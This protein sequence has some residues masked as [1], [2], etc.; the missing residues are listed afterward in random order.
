MERAEKTTS[1]C[2]VFL[3]TGRKAKMTNRD[4][5]MLILGLIFNQLTGC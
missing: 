2:M 4:V 5:K 3:D 1:H